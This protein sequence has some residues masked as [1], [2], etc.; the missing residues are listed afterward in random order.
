METIKTSIVQMYPLSLIEEGKKFNI[1]LGDSE[2]IELKSLYY[3][4]GGDLGVGLNQITF[5]LYRKSDVS[6]MSGIMK[7]EADII[8]ST[9]LTTKFVTESLKCGWTDMIHFPSPLILIRPPSIIA[10]ES[11]ITV[12]SLLVRIYYLIRRVSKVEM[13]K[14]MM[15]DHE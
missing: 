12:Y 1:N 3:C 7:D 9:R 4:T 15:K 5:G 13:A 6:S 8:W 2:V 11:V 14:L 10:Q